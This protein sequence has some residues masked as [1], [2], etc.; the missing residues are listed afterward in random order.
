MVIVYYKDDIWDCECPVREALFEHYKQCYPN[1][2][3]TISNY[4][5]TLQVPIGELELD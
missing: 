4:E 3:V 2:L 1:E 5:E